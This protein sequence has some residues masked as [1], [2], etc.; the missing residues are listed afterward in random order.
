MSGGFSFNAPS[1]T[2]AP[3]GGLFGAKTPTA[4][5]GGS[6]FGN[7]GGASSGASSPSLFG[8]ANTSSSQNNPFGAKTTGAEGGAS[9]PAFNFGGASSPFGG[10]NQTPNKTTEAAAPAQTQT[11][12]GLF[13]AK[14]GTGGGLFGSNTPAQTKPGSNMFSTT[15]ANPP[16]APSLFGAQTSQQAL[17]GGGLTSQATTTEKATTSQPPAGGL[18]GQAPATTATTDKPLFGAAPTT[19]A[20]TLFGA[21]K[22]P[23]TSEGGTKSLFGTATASPTTTTQAPSSLFK[24]PAANAGGNVPAS[25]FGAPAAT[26]SPLQPTTT[27]A[28]EA[29][30]Q[31]SLFSLGGTS[32]TTP[33]STPAAAP[34][35]FSLGKPAATTDTSTS[36]TAAAPA[37]TAPSGG[38]FGAKPATTTTTTTTA[39]PATTATTAAATTTAAAPAAAAPAAPSGA[40]KAATP[41]LGASTFGPTP[42][43]QS[44]LKNKTMDEI[45][46]RWATDLTKY[47]KE[48]KEQAEKVAEWDR[49]LVVNSGKVQKIFGNTVDAERAT[50]E[51]ERQLASVEGQQ[52]E[53]NAWLDRY[54]REVDEMLSKQVGPGETLQ[55]PDQE[56]ERTYKLAEKLSE[57]LDEMGKDLGSM[58]EEINNASSTL[59]KTNKTDEP[60]SQIVRILNS[61]LS[62]LQMIDQ[63]TAELQAKVSAA[64]KAGQS[65]GSR[66]G[67]Y[68]QNGGSIGVGGSA[69]DDF[70][71]SYMGRR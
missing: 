24:L 34:S 46:T 26:A 2:G 28:S 31:K 30:P 19:S 1:S 12:G 47:Q 59:S 9:A 14:P 63:G 49:M 48:F 50:Q 37:T 8:T 4:T 70:Y 18:F 65:L 53:L 55:G 25:P 11:A 43:A 71:R 64:R 69:A 62:Q 10:M 58:I 60:I 17:P 41:N 16:S 23:A 42:P 39:A 22:P 7:L 57:R 36:T 68:G 44:R 32:S 52:E 51:V 67:G 54:E 40:P 13:G 21:P 66:L 6:L 33:S 29:T 20:S 38:L 15:P 3:S 61:H 5:T 56:R 35:L 27:A 45:I